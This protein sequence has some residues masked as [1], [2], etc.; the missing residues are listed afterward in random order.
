VCYFEGGGSRA[1][2][3]Q[4]GGGTGR[5]E[6]A[7]YVDG[8]PPE[9]GRRKDDSQNG[10]KGGGGGMKRLLVETRCRRADREGPKNRGEGRGIHATSYHICDEP[11]GRKRKRQRHGFDVGIVEFGGKKR[12]GKSPFIHMR[13]CDGIR[14]KGGAKAG[15]RTQNPFARTLGGPLA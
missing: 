4:S 14:I 1:H 8:W 5:D 13:V 2:C 9:K 3:F 11:P 15:E 7:A 10:L 6:A 12:E